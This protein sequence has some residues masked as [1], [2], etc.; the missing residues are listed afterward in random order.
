MADLRRLFLAA[1]LSAS[2]APVLACATCGCSLS[3]DAA[4]GYTTESGWRMSLQYDWID[5]KQLRRGTH[6]ISAHDVAAINDAGGDQEVEHDTVNRY[7]TLGLSWAPNADWGV[8]LLVPWVDRGHS[9]YGSSTN[10]L[11]PDDLS[12]AKI[13]GLGDMRVLGTYQGL[14]PGGNLGLQFGVKLP[15]G[16]YGGPDADGTGIAGRR[17]VAF[18]DGP[19][20]RQ[21]SPDNLVDTSLQP[22]TGSTDVLLGAFWHTAVT[23]EVDTFVNA[24]FQAAVSERPHQAGADFRPGN[25]TFVSVGARYEADPALIPQLQVNVSHK[26]ADRGALA[27]NPDSA[28]TVVYVSPGATWSPQPRV[29]VFA[30][31]QIPVHSNLVGIQLAPRWTASGGVSVGF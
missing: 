21:D 27:D 12:S 14:L 28:G 6:A 19:L 3:S 16:R 23:H 25:T 22:G 17:P 9:T 24:Q 8:R 31:A 7:T 18:R 29:Q 1:A 20:S 2:A 13:V 4:M 10:P 11:T 26:G 30:F 5:Q 15:T